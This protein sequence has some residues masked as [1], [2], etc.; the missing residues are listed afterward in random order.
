MKKSFADILSSLDSLQRR[1]VEEKLPSWSTVEGIEFPGSLSLQQCSG[2]EAALYKAGLLR[3]LTGLPDGKAVVADITGGLGVD[4]WAFAACADRVFHNEPDPVLSEAA[5]RNFKRLHRD[6]ITCTCS[7]ARSFL[8]SAREHFDLIYADPSRRDGAGR[9]VFRPE[10]CSPDIPALLPLIFTLTDILLL[11]LSPMADISMLASRLGSRLKELLVCAYDGECKELLCVLDGRHPGGYRI[12][13]PGVLS[14]TPEEEKK[15]RPVVLDRAPAVGETLL[16]PAPELGKAGCFG[17]L[18]E[19]FG[20]VQ[21]GR[22]VHL[23]ICPPGPE[24]GVLPGAR[25]RIDAVLPM[26][27]EGIRAVRKAYPR[28]EVSARGIGMSSEALR[29]RLRCRPGGPYHVFGVKTAS[30]YLLL[31]AERRA[32]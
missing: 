24:A 32:A 12:T 26:G 18:C 31:A 10:D 19:R 14:F 21:L 8:E 2:E 13:V 4:S 11:K 3:S 25:Y 30:G 23:F 20:L 17:L 7:D 5:A 29:A 15:A 9:K 27:D 1:K 22:D 28:S 6:N 16:V